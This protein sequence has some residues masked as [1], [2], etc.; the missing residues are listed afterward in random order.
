MDAMWRLINS[1][2]TETDERATAL[3][4]FESVAVAINYSVR[5]TLRVALAGVTAVELS[6]TRLSADR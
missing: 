3:L 4:P 5:S 6:T 1:P 2:A